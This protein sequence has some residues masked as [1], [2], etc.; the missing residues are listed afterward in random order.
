LSTTV[1]HGPPHAIEAPS[2]IS[3]V[4]KTVSI[5]NR[6]SPPGTTARILPM[7]VMMPVNIPAP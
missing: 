5:S 7:S 6:V 4:S 1:R 3:A 2:A